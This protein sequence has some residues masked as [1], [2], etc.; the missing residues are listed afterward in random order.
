LRVLGFA[1]ALSLATGVIFG[2]FPAL[3]ASRVHANSGL[4]ETGRGSTAGKQRNRLR[5]VLATSEIALALV[6]VAGAGLLIRSFMAV[7]DTDPGFRPERSLAILASL[8]ESQYDKAAAV[9]NFD[10]Q[11]LAKIG[12]IP[13]VS[14]VGAGSMVPLSETNWNQTI[15]PEG[16][17]P[18]S[19]LPLAYHTVVMGDYFGALGI[20]LKRGRLF[21][22]S[23][24]AGSPGSVIINETTARKFWP[25]QNPLG[26][27][28]KYGGGLDSS[29]PWEI[30][31]GVIADVKQNSIEH[32]AEIQVYQPYT[33]LDDNHIAD[34]GRNLNF[35]MRT[36]VDPASVSSAVRLS[37]RSLDPSLP[38]SDLRTMQQVVSTSTAPRRFNTWLLGLLAGIAL[39][40]AAVGIYG[41]MAYSVAMRTQEIGI[42]MALGAAKTNVLRMVLR[43]AF[44]IAGAGIG[45]GLIA[46]F[47]LTRFMT[48]LLYEIKPADPLTFV[49]VSL[50]LAII[51]IA[52]TCFPAMRAMRVDPM[53]A[54]RHE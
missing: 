28:L 25:G 1:A 27:R 32:E 19:K 18:Q 30:V 26:K 7:R 5:I 20:P 13:G 40:I 8:P 35:V 44:V 54:L 16:H 33:Q 34:L 14:T 52:A 24:R 47:A 9:K 49:A 53:V 45:I 51:V 3:A 17:D 2:L 10:E 42:R 21:D 43:Q 4:S 38:A 12:S 15:W 46:G 37:L 6:L 31:V 36:S 22:A 11:F 39:L 50:F 29:R 23:D 41:V 48:G